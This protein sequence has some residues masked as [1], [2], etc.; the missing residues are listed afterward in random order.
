MCTA[1]FVRMDEEGLHERVYRLHYNEGQNR[2]D[3]F[4][5]VRFSALPSI[6]HIKACQAEPA[7][8]CRAM[9]VCMPCMHSSVCSSAQPLVAGHAHA[10]A[11]HMQMDAHVDAHHEH[12][13]A[14][15][16]LKGRQASHW[17]KA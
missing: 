14:G 7:A 5:Q 16:P 1:K 2:C 9:H 6:A 12:A 10:H 17:G 8:R 3:S 4:A 13:P 15:Q 11:Y